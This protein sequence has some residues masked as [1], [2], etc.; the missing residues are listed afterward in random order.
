MAQRR[1]GYGE[2]SIHQRPDGRWCATIGLGVIDGKRKRKYLYGD[3]R[4]EVVEKLKAA[5]SAQ[6]SGTN[7]AAE[8]IIV[9]QFLER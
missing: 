3:T 5:Q 9:T 1:G 2:G 6:A 7:L 4:R 8:R